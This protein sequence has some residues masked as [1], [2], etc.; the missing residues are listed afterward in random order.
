MVLGPNKPLL[1]VLSITYKLSIHAPHV[2]CGALARMVWRLST[3][4]AEA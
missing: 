3:C 4:C 2:M 1:A